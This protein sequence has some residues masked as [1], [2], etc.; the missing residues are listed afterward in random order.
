M[1][2]SKPEP[3]SITRLVSAEEREAAVSRLTAAF[4][5][6]AIAVDEF[7]RRVAEVYEAKT[8]KA[9]AKVTHDLPDSGSGT[10]SVPAP[11][12]RPTALT[13][14]PA[15][16]VSSILSSIERKVHGPVPE[17]LDIRAVAGSAEVDL[18]RAEFPPGV[19]EIRVDAILGN[20]ELELPDY[21]H[22]EH[23][24]RA[25]LANFSVKGRTRPRGDGAVPVVRI[26]GRSIFANV[27]VELD[28]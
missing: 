22:V 14:P 24:G 2:D 20:I 15:Q 25:F 26:T 12:E 3:A 17:Q 1:S 18:R 4:A 27:E 8:A 19:T 21:V 13:R 6:D 16:E 11:A 23:E 7:E 5:Q 9:L 10:S 28:D